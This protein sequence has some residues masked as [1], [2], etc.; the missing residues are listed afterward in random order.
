MRNSTVLVHALDPVLIDVWVD[1]AFYEDMGSGDV[2]AQLIPED[3][4]VSA[5][6]MAKEPAVVCGLDFVRA[7]FLKLDPQARLVFYVKDSDSVVSGQLLLS[8]TGNA[9]ALLSAERTA[10]NFLQLLS[11]TA[12][13]V[14]LYVKLIAHTKAKLL[15][16]RKTLPGLRLAQKYAVQC[17][18]GMNHRIGLYDAYLIKENHIAACGG[19]TAAVLEA[20]RQR[21][22]LFLEVEVETL[23]QLQE[24]LPLKVERVM[25]DNFTLPQIQE[26]VA[27]VAGRVPLEVSG[28]IDQDS[29]VKMAETG[30]DFISMGSLTKHVRAIDY[31]LRVSQ[32]VLHA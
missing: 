29:I 11:G 31:S 28:N 10:L 5:T 27:W 13:T 17:G 1:T 8:L 25:L 26:A 16:T 7:A 18:G 23:Q 6:I 32:R 15:D 30:V 21:P 20:R 12:T 19:I 3:Q 4:V 9:R 14:D 2:T 22:D 24:V